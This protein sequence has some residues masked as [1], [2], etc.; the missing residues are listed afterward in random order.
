M[1]KPSLSGPPGAPDMSVRD[2]TVLAVRAAEYV[3]MS[4]EQ[5]TCSPIVQRQVIAQYAE[6]HGLELVRRYADEGKSGLTLDG[7]DGL[8][9]LLA[10]SVRF[11][12]RLCENSA[13]QAGYAELASP[14]PRFLALCCTK[15]PSE[16]I[17]IASG[18]SPR[19]F[20]TACTPL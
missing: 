13:F 11:P 9:S 5:Q 12:P 1:L 6:Q 15:A 18:K 20:H 3:R 10:D 4:T 19:G 14:D 8:R 2:P 17:S 16:M 7:R